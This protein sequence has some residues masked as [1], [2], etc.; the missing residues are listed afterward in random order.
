MLVCLYIYERFEDGRM[1][2]IK[3]SWYSDIH[4]CKKHLKWNS[5]SEN[6]VWHLVLDGK[7]DDTLPTLDT[8]E[9]KKQLQ[10]FNDKLL[11]AIEKR[12]VEIENLG[13]NFEVI[14]NTD[15]VAEAKKL[16]K[17]KKQFANYAKSYDRFLQ[18]ILFKVYS[19]TPS[20]DA[21]ISALRQ[22]LSKK[23]EIARTILGDTSLKFEFFDRGQVKSRKKEVFIDKETVNK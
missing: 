22:A 23:L 7:V 8:D 13:L 1:Y 18:Q 15:T 2:K 10:A 11:Q 3:S 12:C 14:N 16:Y 4:R 6:H 17:D 21:I 5:L 9:E 19:G 20:E